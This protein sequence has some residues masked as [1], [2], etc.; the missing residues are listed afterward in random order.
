VG[1]DQGSRRQHHR[2]AQVTCSKVHIVGGPGS[3]KA[4]LAARLGRWLDVPVHDLDAIAYDSRG[5]QR[6][7][8]QRR[9][10]AE[11]I[12]ATPG[13]ITEGIYLSFCDPLACSAAAGRGR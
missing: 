8:E 9:A 11:R 3:G 13:W 10:A 5:R 4:T 6:D 7:L 12:A 1:D 2:T